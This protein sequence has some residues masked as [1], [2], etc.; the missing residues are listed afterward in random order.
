MGTGRSTLNVDSGLC[1][2]CSTLV[3]PSGKSTLVFFGKPPFFPT[4]LHKVWVELTSP[5]VPLG[6][7]WPRPGSR[8]RH[9][10]LAAP[11]CVGRGVHPDGWVPVLHQ[12]CFILNWTFP[13]SRSSSGR[14]TTFR[15]CSAGGVKPEATGS[16]ALLWNQNEL[17]ELKRR[18][19]QGER[20]AD[21]RGP[22]EPEAVLGV[23]SCRTQS[24]LRF[25]LAIFCHRL[26][27]ECPGW[28]SGSADFLAAIGHG[29]EASSGSSEGDHHPTLS[30]EKLSV[31]YVCLTQWL[32]GTN[33]SAPPRRAFQ[34]L[35]LFRVDA[36][37][38]PPSAPV[39]FPAGWGWLA[40]TGPVWLW[41]SL[42]SWEPQENTIHTPW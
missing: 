34:A 31:P 4:L 5:R 20:G 30:T 29:A 8:G 15:H 26:L 25:A 12:L 36:S 2:F 14:D 1:F 23:F 18:K 33:I 32:Y 27:N 28:C 40:S 17:R 16:P 9:T 37:L 7:S 42:D 6:A 3:S 35:S 19:E 41:E 13:L 21:H 10:P 39:V 11:V 38:A 24:T 22:T